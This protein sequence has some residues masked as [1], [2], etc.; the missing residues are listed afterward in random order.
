MLWV[1][2]M[3]EFSSIIKREFGNPSQGNVVG[4]RKK[5]L[6]DAFIYNIVKGENIS[7]CMYLI[8]HV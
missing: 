3:M 8:A 1:T 2:C 7:V 5:I 6:Q 4:E